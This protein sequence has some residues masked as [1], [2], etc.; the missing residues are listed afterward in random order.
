MKKGVRVVSVLLGAFLSASALADNCDKPR[1]D[2]DG[3]YCLNRVYQ[4]ADNELNQEYKSL[5]SYLSESEKSALK[6]RQVSWIKS[7]NEQCSFRKDGMFF[8]SLSCTTSMTVDRT[9]VL[10]DR[11]RECKS[12]GCQSSKL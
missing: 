10:R 11:I 5:R 6:S 12:T 1:D 3:L 9:N 8:V 4:E 7:R 2:F